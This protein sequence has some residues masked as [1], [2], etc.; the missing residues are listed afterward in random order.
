MR[1]KQVCYIPSR[2]LRSSCPI[3]IPPKIMKTMSFWRPGDLRW[4]RIDNINSPY[5]HMHRDLVY[6]TENFYAVDWNGRVLVYD[7]TGS[8]PIHTQ[9]VAIL[10]PH[11]MGDE[12]Y[13]LESI[14]SLF[15]VVRYGV[16]SRP[17]IRED[18]SRRI[19]LTPIYPNDGTETY[20]TTNFGVF[21]VDLAAG[22]LRETKQVGDRALFLGANASISVQA[23]QFPGVKPNHI[24]Y[25][26]DF[27]E[28]YLFYEEGGGRDMG[29]Y[30]IANGSFEPHYNGVSLSRVCPPIWVTPTLY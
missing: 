16:K 21:E 17:P 30:N 23:S 26:D 8:S 7:V 24:Y 14:G 25:T 15:V 18:S 10:P 22:E 27:V 6:Y 5:K 12:F 3:Q 4:T 11:H 2:V 9:I 13:I 20:G 1:M 28:S 29:V 19:S